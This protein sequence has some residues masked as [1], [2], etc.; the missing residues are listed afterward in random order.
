MPPEPTEILRTPDLKASC[1]PDLLYVFGVSLR[2]SHRLALR[3]RP[4]PENLTYREALWAFAEELPGRQPFSPDDLDLLR[5]SLTSTQALVEMG[6]PL[7][8]PITL[9]ALTHA[10]A[11]VNRWSTRGQPTCLVA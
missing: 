7:D 5:R 2:T 3:A 9:D 4:T 10:L 11:M 1:T 8:H 6:R